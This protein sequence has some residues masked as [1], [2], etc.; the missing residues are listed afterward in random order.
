MSYRFRKKAT[1]AFTVGVVAGTLVTSGAGH[2][3]QDESEGRAMALTEAVH[4][5]THRASRATP[6]NFARSV[7]AHAGYGSRQYHCLSRLWQRESRW[8]PDAHNRRSGAYGIPQRIDGY[9]KPFMDDYR[10]QIVWGVAYIKSRYGTPCA[11]LRHQL[12]KG[13]Y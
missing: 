3:P 10:G 9:G 12:R 2:S 13:W 8:N 7:L 6:R 11:A 1:A 5:P 4:T